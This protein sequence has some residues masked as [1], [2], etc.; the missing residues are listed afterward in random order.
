MPRRSLHPSATAES[1]ALTLIAAAGLTPGSR[2]EAF[3]G[4]V[5]AGF[6]VGQDPEPGLAVALGT[7]VN[8]VISKGPDLSPTPAPASPTITS[9]TAPSGVDCRDPNFPG[10]IHLAWSIVSA[11]G[12]TLSIDGTGVYATYQGTDGADD[13]PFS[14]GE[15]RHSYLLTTI[16]GNGPADRELIVVPRINP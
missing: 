7:A 3:D 14:C 10:T 11:T 9:F 1:H 5:P 2:G 6:V 13:V 16:G 12:A 4:S 15:E 8:Y